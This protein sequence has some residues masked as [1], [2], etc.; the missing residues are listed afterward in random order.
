MN[1]I[2]FA[3]YADNNTPY[4]VGNNIKDVIINL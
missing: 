2:D 4:V 1:E 3:S